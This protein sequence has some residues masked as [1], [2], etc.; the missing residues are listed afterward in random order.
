VN[1]LPQIVI[2]CPPNRS[3]RDARIKQTDG[4]EVPGR[5]TK[6]VVTVDWA[7][8]AA[9][10]V[11]LTAIVPSFDIAAGVRSIE[12]NGR[13]FRLVEV[14]HVTPMPEASAPQLHD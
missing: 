12:L 9:P 3:S 13:K 11:D 10:V 1:D 6:A 8:G 4:S 2:T 14:D 7:S 5:Y